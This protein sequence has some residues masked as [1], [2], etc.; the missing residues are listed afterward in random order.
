MDAL[1]FKGDYEGMQGALLEERMSEGVAI[2]L[3]VGEELL[4]NTIVPSEY[5]ER[6]LLRYRNLSFGFPWLSATITRRKGSLHVDE[7]SLTLIGNPG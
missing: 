5:P 6:F 3:I 4:R 7:I 1:F 2:K